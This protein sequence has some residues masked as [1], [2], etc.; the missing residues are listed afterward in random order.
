[1]TLLYYL[2]SNLKVK[3]VILTLPKK[4]FP[5]DVATADVLDC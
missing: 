5:H 1:M 4:I 2:Y 3:N